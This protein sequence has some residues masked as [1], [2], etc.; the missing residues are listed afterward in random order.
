MPIHVHT[1][2]I[3]VEGT[4]KEAETRART[5]REFLLD[6]CNVEQILG[7]TVAMGEP[8]KTLKSDQEELNSHNEFVEEQLME[9]EEYSDED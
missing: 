8:A 1:L 5:L 2:R 4:E 9:N 7:V 6:D 3:I